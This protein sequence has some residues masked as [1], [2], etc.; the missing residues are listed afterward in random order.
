MKPVV[1]SLVLL[2]LPGCSWATESFSTAYFE[3]ENFASQSGGNKAS[4]EYFPYIGEG[5]LEMGRQGAAVTW[6]NITVPKA[7][8]YTLLFKYANN[9]DHNL[10]CDLKVNGTL[11]KNIPFGQF[12]KAWIAWP[13]A[14]SEYTE[15][16][17]GWAKYW[18][19][20][21]IVD[22]KAGANTLEL[23]ATSAAGGPHIDNI[24]VSTAVSEPPAP[25]VN[26]KDCGAVGDGS[27]DNTE[28][29][30]KAIAACPAGGSVVFDEG[31][32]MTGSVTLKANMTL[33]ISENAVL[34]AIK[35]KVKNQ[36]YPEGAFSGG[37]ITR[38]FLFG[39]QVDNLTITGGGTIDGNTTERLPGNANTLRPTMLGW[40]NSQN[41]TVTNIDLI[42]GDFWAFVP[43]KSDRVVID[44][45]NLFNLNKDGIAPLDCHDI[46]ITNSV[47]SAGDDALTPKSYSSKG[48]DNLVVKNVTINHCRWKGIKFGFSSIG[49]FTNCLFEDIAMV[50]VQA[51]ITVLL[52]DGGSAS[53]LTFNRIN[54]NNVHTPITLLNGGGLRSKAPGITTMKDITISNLEARNVYDPMGSFITG[55]KVGDTIHKA[56]NIYLTN[57]KVNSFKGGLTEVPGTPIEYDGR[58]ADVRLFGNFPAWGYYIRHADNVVFENVTHSV[59]PADVREDIVLENVIGFRKR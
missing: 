29:I 20:R 39:N 51:G 31:V 59:S 54:M 40:V 52:I 48:I 41:V 12:P 50:H 30:A 18:N 46:V 36:T 49:D 10:P 1:I 21:V 37:Y 25:V 4:T 47:I 7:G 6:N 17:V 56:E 15:D 33:W 32:Y 24:G 45:I 23:I 35:E 11:I 27:T 8:K 5:Y 3:A 26:V 55:T 14:A 13:A 28:S 16:K 38:Y 57:V 44:G 2:C 22:L 34:R 42:N 58:K 9:T 19:A 53:N 43:Q